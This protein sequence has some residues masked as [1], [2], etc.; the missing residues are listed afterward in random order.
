[1]M[2]WK[3][4]GDIREQIGHCELHYRGGDSTGTLF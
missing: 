1:M 3:G 2:A 4:F